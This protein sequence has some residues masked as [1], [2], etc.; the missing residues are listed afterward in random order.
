MQGKKLQKMLLVKSKIKNPR[1]K[2]KAA[3]KQSAK[4]LTPGEQLDMVFCIQTAVETEVSSNS[5]IDSSLDKALIQENE[6]LIEM[7]N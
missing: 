4:Q 7:E 5:E 1:N 6:D 2:T 3:Y